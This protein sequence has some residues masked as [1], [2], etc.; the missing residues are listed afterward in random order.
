MIAAGMG[1]PAALDLDKL[2]PASTSHSPTSFSRDIMCLS[3]C[4]P[5]GSRFSRM[6]PCRQH[7]HSIWSINKKIET[8]DL[9]ESSHSMLFWA[10]K[11]V[12]NL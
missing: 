3:L 5:R 8:P 7:I 12:Q 4:I 11:R 10:T 6:L 9:N 1:C 2:S